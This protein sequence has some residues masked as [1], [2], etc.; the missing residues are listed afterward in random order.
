MLVHQLPGACLEGLVERLAVSDVLVHQAVPEH[1][2][3][4]VEDERLVL[5][6]HRF[7]DSV[8]ALVRPLLLQDGDVGERFVHPVAL[9]LVVI[10]QIREVE[11]SPSDGLLVGR[12]QVLVLGIVEVVER[13]GQHR[14]AGRVVADGVRDRRRAG[15]RLRRL[16]GGR[17]PDAQAVGE[18]RPDAD[19]QPGDPPHH[20]LE[21][22][23]VTG[24][25]ATTACAVITPHVLL[26]SR[27][28]V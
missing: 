9:D 14:R 18:I 26:P 12:R 22:S 7:G 17:R 8:A 1:L 23:P 4:F 15:E 19:H 16:G 21:R 6:E 5:V 20:R 2:R 25:S 28:I 3:Q 27:S 24:P 11:Q 13:V 10:L